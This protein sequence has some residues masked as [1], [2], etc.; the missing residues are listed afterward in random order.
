MWVVVFVEA[1]EPAAPWALLARTCTLI[2]PF[3][4][5]DPNTFNHLPLAKS[6]SVITPVTAVQ[7]CVLLSGEIPTLTWN[8]VAP[9]LEIVNHLFWAGSSIR[10]YVCVVALLSL[11]HVNVNNPLG[12][13]TCVPFTMPW[14]ALV[15]TVN[16]PVVGLYDE[17]VVGVWVA[18]AA[19]GYVL[20][21]LPWVQLNVNASSGIIT[22]SPS[23]TLWF[24]PICN[25]TTPSAGVYKV[26]WDPD[27][28]ET[29]ND[30]S[31]TEGATNV[32]AVAPEPLAI[33]TSKTIFDF[34]ISIEPVEFWSATNVWAPPSDVAVPSLILTSNVSSVILS[35][36]RA[37]LASGSVALG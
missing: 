9:T 17:A 18:D 4:L 32:W 26:V 36:G 2:V 27:P 8:V 28:A 13:L 29:V 12:N 22:Y 6:L 15:V 11:A 30:E 24:A 10:G 33:P 31:F 37:V 5:S 20:F 7:V 19:L 14:A 35:T 34:K 1:L 3:V 21:P 16:I 25:L 23:L